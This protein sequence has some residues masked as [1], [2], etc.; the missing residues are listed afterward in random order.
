[1]G[2]H[3]NPMTPP[4]GSATESLNDQNHKLTSRAVPVLTVTTFVSGTG[5]L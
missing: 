1:M 3:V 5:E 4:L 2:G